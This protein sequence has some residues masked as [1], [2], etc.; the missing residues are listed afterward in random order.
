MA[1]RA[2]FIP[3]L[4]TEADLLVPSQAGAN[5]TFQ[6]TCSGVCYNDYVLNAD[7]CV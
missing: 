1:A 4:S 3:H 6:A 2:A 7:R 5:A